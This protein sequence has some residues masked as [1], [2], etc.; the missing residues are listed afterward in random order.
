MMTKGEYPNLGCYI[1]P[2]GNLKQNMATQIRL[3][4]CSDD[5]LKLQNVLIPES[6]FE[7]NS[8]C[9]RN[10]PHTATRVSP[11]LHD[12]SL[13]LVVRRKEVGKHEKS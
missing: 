11:N 4:A 9:L 10:S 2:Y 1:L 5:K 7:P 13:S 8:C 12:A 6:P 3:L